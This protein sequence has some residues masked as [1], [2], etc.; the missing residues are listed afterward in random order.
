MDEAVEAWNGQ[1]VFVD[2]R[3]EAFFQI[4]HIPGALNLPISEGFAPVDRWLA[5][6][7]MEGTL[8]VYCSDASCSDSLIVAR[9]FLLHGYQNVR[10]FRGGWEEWQAAELPEESLP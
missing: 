5:V 2:A 9:R 10:V 3:E 7:N 1:S 6:R 8:F 4:G